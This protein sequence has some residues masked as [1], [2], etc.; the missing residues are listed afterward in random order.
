MV[1]L[2]KKINLV[3]EVLEK[4][5]IG[6]EYGQIVLALDISG[7]MS[8]LFQNGT[9][10]RLVERLLAIG[11]NMDSDKQIDV[12]LFGQKAHTAKSA[13][14]DNIEDFVKK[15]ITN[16][17]RLEGST[18]Y[19]GVM[20]NIAKER[21]NL[22][23]KRKKTGGLFGRFKKELPEDEVKSEVKEPTIVFFITDG[24]NFDKSET[25]KLIRELSGEGIFWQF[26]GIGNENFRYLK[27][28]D[29]MDGRVIDNANFFAA[30]D[31]NKISDEELYQRILGEL[32]DWFR[33]A[34]AK[35]IIK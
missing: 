31:I 19:A 21:G 18:N 7:S 16:K 5:Q 33:E 2:E 26:I 22:T 13:N 6:N 12:H 4:K 3:K 1:N 27:S 11:V 20:K 28:L 9:V 8:G 30:N 25:T 24:D 10:Q 15:E 23:E 34:K 14:I 32:P 35:N 17:F 29:E